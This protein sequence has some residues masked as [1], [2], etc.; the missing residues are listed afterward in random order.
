M[1]K[2]KQ[3]DKINIKNYLLLLLI[4]VLGIGITLYLSRLYD[5]YDEYQKQ[6]P[7]IRDTLSEISSEELEHYILENPTTV[8]YMCTSSDTICRDFEK[9]FKKL[10]K[11]NALQ[12]DIIYLN[13]S[14]ID[15]EKFVN[16]FNSSYNFRNKLTTKYPAIV[17]FEDGEVRNILQG[18]ENE[19]LTIKRT[20][21]FI[22]LNNIGETDE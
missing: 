14:D 19:K 13:L 12:D 18:K 8:I 3:Q 9:D 11:K 6:T 2:K 22:E 20:E 17:M 16:D 7:V 15:Q 1:T 10:I 21:Q 4:F 5:V